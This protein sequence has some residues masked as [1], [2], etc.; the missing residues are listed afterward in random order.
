[1]DPTIGRGQRGVLGAS[2]VSWTATRKTPPQTD[3]RHWFRT[4][5]SLG[6]KHF[7]EED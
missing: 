6:A 2:G 7:E 4:Y 3:G 1:M 5:D